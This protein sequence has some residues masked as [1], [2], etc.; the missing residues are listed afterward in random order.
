MAVN[1]QKWMRGLS[2][3]LL[4]SIALPIFPNVKFEYPTQIAE[5]IN[6]LEALNGLDEEPFRSLNYMDRVNNSSEFLEFFTF[7]IASI[8]YLAL[9]FISFSLFIPNYLPQPPPQ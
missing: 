2:L 4:V 9:I 6:Y 3:I 7:L 5:N 1:L 8:L